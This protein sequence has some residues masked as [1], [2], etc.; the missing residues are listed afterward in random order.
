MAPARNGT[1]GECLSCKRTV[2]IM[3]K[4]L[5]QTC[6]KAVGRLYPCLYLR[7]RTYPPCVS[8]GKRSGCRPRGLCDRCRYPSDRHDHAAGRGGK[9]YGGPKLSREPTEA[10]L[11]E[12]IAYQ[13]R[14]ENLPP[15]WKEDDRD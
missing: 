2:M 7:R 3:A 15:W 5:C 10:E 13:M 9:G 6:Y 14:P 1:P 12:L 4:G 11:D 8:C